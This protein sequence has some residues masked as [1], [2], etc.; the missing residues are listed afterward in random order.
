MGFPS[1]HN[2]PRSIVTWPSPMARPFY[3][4]VPQQHRNVTFPHG[5]PPLS[6]RAPPTICYT[7][8][9][10]VKHATHCIAN[11]V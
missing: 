10:H 3:Y 11:T 4:N 1:Y 6:Q 7:A 2:V 5:L 8:V 9:Y